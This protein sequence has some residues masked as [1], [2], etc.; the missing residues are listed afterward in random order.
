MKDGM[1]KVD[2]I[3]GKVS[4][5]SHRVPKLPKIIP[6]ANI[7]E[8]ISPARFRVDLDA[9]ALL[10]KNSLLDIGIFDLGE[11]TRFNL[12]AGNYLSKSFDVRY[13]VHAS[14]I[15][16]GLDYWAQKGT[17]IQA[18]LYDTN[19]PRLDVKAL[20]RVNNIASF[21]IGGDNLLRT[22]IPLV[23]IQLTH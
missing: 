12:Q 5:T 7:S 14:K 16:A 19:T 10:G 21:W 6:I 17:G 9:W 13:G 8:Q 23:G 11:D 20:Y 22:P 18:D 15:G 1:E 2:Q 4:D 3:L